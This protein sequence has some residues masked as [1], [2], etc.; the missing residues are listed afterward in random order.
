MAFGVGNIAS[1]LTGGF[2]VGSSTSR[3]A[4]V[5]G[6]FAKPLPSIVTSVGTLLLVLFGTALL[7]HIPNPAIGAVVPL[8]GISEFRRLWQ[9][10]RGESAVGAVCFLG[11]PFLGRIAG[12]AVAFILS[13]VVLASRAASPLVAVLSRTGIESGALTPVTEAEP[14]NAPAWSS[15]ASRRRSSLPT[16]PSSATKPGRPSAA[17]TPPT[18]P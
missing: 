5:A 7:E 17:A 9:Q 13:L 11:A 10:D 16:A 14:T 2:T 12:I 6:R 3:T 8:L 15:S 1:G 18:H 4:A